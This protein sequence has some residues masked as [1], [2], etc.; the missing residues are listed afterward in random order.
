MSRYNTSKI[1]RNFIYTAFLVGLVAYSIFNSRIFITGPQ[2]NVLSPENGATVTESPLIKVSG[3]A[4]NIS[5]IELNGKRINVNEEGKF[6]EPTLLYPGYNIVTII[7]TDKFNRSVEK[8]IELVYKSNNEEGFEKELIN[9]NDLDF[10]TTTL[11]TS[12]SSP[13]TSLEEI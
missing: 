2:I 6:N 8:K 5:F 3:T 4:E 12:T 9:E 1:I 10:S 7:A 11:E 13:T